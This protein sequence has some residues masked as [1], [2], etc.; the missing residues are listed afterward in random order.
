MWHPTRRFVSAKLRTYMYQR[1]RHFSP[2]NTDSADL[3]KLDTGPKNRRRVYRS[4]V[5]CQFVINFSSIFAGL[6]ELA[7]FSLFPLYR[8]IL[9]IRE[10]ILH[11]P[12]GPNIA[13]TLWLTKDRE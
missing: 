10:N 13:F 2:P 1:F 4:A 11:L 12:Y 5:I 9:K 8:K 7:T 3:Y 6:T